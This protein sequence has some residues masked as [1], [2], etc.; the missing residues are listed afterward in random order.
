VRDL[1]S[2][3]CKILIKNI[4]DNTNNG[5]SPAITGTGNV[6]RVGPVANGASIDVSTTVTAAGQPFVIAIA[7]WS[8]FATGDASSKI[9]CIIDGV[10]QA[11][12]TGLGRRTAR[13]TKDTGTGSITCIARA[14]NEA[15]STDL[16]E[17]LINAVGVSI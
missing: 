17:L 6:T 16:D 11:T 1:Y 14:H 8:S 3:N 2:K 7:S 5:N 15:V 12:D 4:K 10:I 13:G 9:E